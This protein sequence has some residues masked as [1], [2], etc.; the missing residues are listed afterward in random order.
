M[1]YL[2]I[3]S[4]GEI[5]PEALSLMGAST[6][7]GDSSKIGMF[8]SGN[9]F[10][11]AYLLR[12]G[13]KPE[14]YSGKERIDLDTV[15]TDFRGT[16]F[17]TITINGAP[18]S[19]TTSMGKD[20]DCWMAIREIFA[21]AIDEG[22]ARITIVDCPVGLT[23]QTNFYIPINE[24]VQEF[25][26]NLE[27]Y[28][29]MYRTP[30]HECSH[31][32]AYVSTGNGILYRMGIRV[33]KHSG[34]SMFDYDLSDIAITEDRAIK[35][36]WKAHEE[37]YKII[38]A[39][40]DRKMI[41]SFLSKLGTPDYFECQPSS[42]ST[43]SLKDCSPLWDDVI[44]GLYFCPREI[45][46]FVKDSERG[47]TTFINGKVFHAMVERFGND[48]LPPSMRG[49]GSFKYRVIDEGQHFR[50]KINKAVGF[51]KLAGV[52]AD[53]YTVQVAEFSN[54]D[55][56]GETNKQ[57]QTIILSDRVMTM[58][59]RQITMTLIEEYLHL[60][61]GAADETREFQDASINLCIS[62]MERLSGIEL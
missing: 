17:D 33:Y 58:G 48:I 45:S 25:A 42:C 23:G 31:G 8:G 4:K 44:K 13:L 54:S 39:F 61:T 52:N 24:E 21:N 16:T 15:T 26:D 11:L 47:M 37:V 59:Q 5:A 22:D 28:F 20:W 53:R 14:I 32:K 57:D 29:S 7:R 12:S 3:T 10:A 34:P 19:L 35:F 51:M 9:K 40:N 36:W 18:T 6:K 56:L 41:N 49:V 60:T 30:L 50:D 2:A 46:G 55:V 27:Q 43:L 38:S 1:K 62:M